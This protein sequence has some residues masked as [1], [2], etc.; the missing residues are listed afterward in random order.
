MWK[1]D[2]SELY[3][4]HVVG[5]EWTLI[6]NEKNTSNFVSVF[7][8]NDTVILKCSDIEPYLSQYIYLNSTGYGQI[9]GNLPINQE[10]IRDNMT[11]FAESGSWL[12]IMF[13]AAGKN[14]YLNHLK[15][16]ILIWY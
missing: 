10:T 5:V 12:T 16:V 1:L 7:R 6:L 4:K 14:H 13:E 11:F 3:Y 2:E 9:D 15:K 8:E